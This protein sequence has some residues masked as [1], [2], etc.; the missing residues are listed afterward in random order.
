MAKGQSDMIKMD[1]TP[2]QLA[3]E[4]EARAYG[5]GSLVIM[6][7]KQ[8]EEIRDAYGSSLLSRIY[9]DTLTILPLRAVETK[10]LKIRCLAWNF[11]AKDLI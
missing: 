1:L 2:E 10:E 5:V 7:T 3:R 8:M 9:V 6:T 4:L 11:K